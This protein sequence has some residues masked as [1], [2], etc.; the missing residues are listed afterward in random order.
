MTQ[1]AEIILDL[2]CKDI[3]DDKKQQNKD[4][5]DRV[6]NR[7]KCPGKDVVVLRAKFKSLKKYKEEKTNAPNLV[8]INT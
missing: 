2:N 5:F 7:I 8:I 1:L 6:A 3:L 4:I